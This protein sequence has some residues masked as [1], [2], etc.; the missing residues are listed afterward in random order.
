MQTPEE[1]A[2]EQ[3]VEYLVAKGITP[4]YAKKHVEERVTEFD[5]TTINGRRF[6]LVKYEGRL[7]PTYNVGDTNPHATKLA[8]ELWS[9]IPEKEPDSPYRSEVKGSL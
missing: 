2:R 7:W 9:E 6:L 5:S 3:V 4:E 8:D 1:Y